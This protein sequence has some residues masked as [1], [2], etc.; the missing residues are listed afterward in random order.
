MGLGVGAEAEQPLS[1]KDVWRK[2]QLRQVNYC[3]YSAE[4]L[5]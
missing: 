5:R 3:E 2:Q 1:A 4:R